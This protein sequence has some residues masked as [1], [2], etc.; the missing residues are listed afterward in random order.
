MHAYLASPL[1]VVGFGPWLPGVT[2]RG[3][4]GRN[5]GVR[6]EGVRAGVAPQQSP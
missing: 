4:E 6:C 1:S 3:V 2:R 5:V